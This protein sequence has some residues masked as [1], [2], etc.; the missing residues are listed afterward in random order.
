M[1]LDFSKWVDWVDVFDEV[2]FVSELLFVEFKEDSSL[3][4]LFWEEPS[5]ELEFF[6]VDELDWD[7]FLLYVPNIA[8]APLSVFV[9]LR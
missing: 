7:S 8:T 4:V 2:S 5:L 9:R 1:S 3:D 6:L